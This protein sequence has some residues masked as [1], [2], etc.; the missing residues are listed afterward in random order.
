MLPNNQEK[1]EEEENFSGSTREN[2]LFEVTL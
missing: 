1:L 2:E